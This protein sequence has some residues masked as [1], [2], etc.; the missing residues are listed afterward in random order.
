MFELSS[1][2]SNKFWEIGQ[3]GDTYTV[4]YGRIG[5]DGR[6]S[7]KK[8]DGAE[9]CANAIEKLVNQKLA[10]GYEEV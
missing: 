6:V 5:A 2:K 3:S 8:F 4:R 7:S 9:A 10:K 1:G